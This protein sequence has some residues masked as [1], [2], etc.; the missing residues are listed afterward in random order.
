MMASFLRSRNG[1][2]LGNGYAPMKTRSTSLYRSRANR[3]AILVLICCGAFVL[4]WAVSDIVGNGL[5]RVFASS[6]R[7]RGESNDFISGHT[8]LSSFYH[9]VWNGTNGRDFVNPKLNSQLWIELE[10]GKPKF[11]FKEL[12]KFSAEPNYYFVTLYDQ[13]RNMRAAISDYGFYIESK[14]GEELDFHENFSG[15]FSVF[16]GDLVDDSPNKLGSSTTPPAFIEGGLDKQE[17]VLMIAAYKDPLC[18]HT[19]FQLFNKAK[20][21]NRVSAIVVEQTD[22]EAQKCE[23]DYVEICVERNTSN[24]LDRVKVDRV[25]VDHSRG[26]MIARYRQ[27]LLL[28]DQEFCFQTDSHMDFPPN[29]DTIA[30]DDWMALDNEMAVITAYPNRVGDMNHN[31]FPPV[32][33]STK[34]SPSKDVVAGGN[35]ALMMKPGAKPYVI[36]FFGAGT[37]FSKCHAITN[38]PYDPYMSY[39]FKGE[40]FD[41]AVRLYTSG[42]DLYSP[43]K[44]FA[45][46]YYDSDEKP[47]LAAKPRSRDFFHQKETKELTE[48]SNL[49]W[50]SILGLPLG[51]SNSKLSDF[52]ML[53]SRYFGLGN[54]RTLNQYE[55]FSGLDLNEGIAIS[56]CP[57]IGHLERVPYNFSI[58]FYPSGDGCPYQRF[59]DIRKNCRTTLNAV[60]ESSLEMLNMTNG[61]MLNNARNSSRYS[62]DNRTLST[63][64]ITVMNNEARAYA[65]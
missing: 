23:E 19:L 2:M 26:V 37:S 36:P 30:L 9:S 15:E 20:H 28:E 61:E 22:D 43:R 48:Q 44:N 59:V 16:N 60:K 1:K 5:Y 34:F 53:N 27:G 55:A 4:V 49:R 64:I 31:A 14:T 65:S 50:R 24:Y 46:H 29:W 51:K 58:P 56:R 42:Y 12:S 47:K 21:P 39:L 10:N 57:R 62:G 11:V 6:G 38:V 3:L 45:F 33:C 63:P 25:R 18:G 7:L 32:R 41:R 52:G 8:N 13:S 17:I 54:R 40:E 35:S